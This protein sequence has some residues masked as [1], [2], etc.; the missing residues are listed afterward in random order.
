M[1]GFR[2]G[3]ATIK[4]GAAPRADWVT[5]TAAGSDV[6]R[7]QQLTKGGWKASSTATIR[8]DGTAKVTFPRLGK[9]GTYAFR[10]VVD[11]AATRVLKVRVR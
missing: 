2:A 6:V 5:V 7:L 8:E 9:R 3:T 1:S 4:R 10:A 11:G